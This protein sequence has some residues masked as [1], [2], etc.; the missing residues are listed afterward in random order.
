MIVP[1]RNMYV[2]LGRRIRAYARGCEMLV[3]SISRPSTWINGNRQR[4]WPSR[5]DL[6]RIRCSLIPRKLACDHCAFSDPFE[7]DATMS[8]CGNTCPFAVTRLRSPFTI[9]IKLEKGDYHLV[10]WHIQPKDL[11][12]GNPPV[13]ST[14]ISWDIALYVSDFLSSPDIFSN[15]AQPIPYLA[16]NASHNF[17]AFQFPAFSNKSPH[18]FNRFYKKMLCHLFCEYNN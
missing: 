18:I 9:E 5:T 8:D 13:C 16:E 11:M 14:L 2:Y 17:C 12:S 7:S 3:I 6:T 15:S 10:V 1:Y 4:G